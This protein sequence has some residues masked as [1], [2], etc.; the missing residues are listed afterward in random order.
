V[1]SQNPDITLATNRDDA[2]IR[3][4]LTQS[5]L[6]TSD[7]DAAQPVIFVARYDGGLAGIGAIELFGTAGLLRSVAVVPS[8][9]KTGLGRAIVQRL[10]EQARESGLFELVLLTETA[11]PF[12]EK[13]GYGVIERSAA[14]M[15]VKGSAE[16][17][18]L[19]PQSAVCMRKQLGPHVKYGP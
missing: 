14:P 6:P 16:F 12:F 9:R 15:A 7:L 5:R 19:C 8:H 17:T 10:E 18:S 2:A 1:T 4:L 3:E 13:L 11:R